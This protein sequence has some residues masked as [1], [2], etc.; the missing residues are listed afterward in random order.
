MHAD[1][2]LAVSF[3]G[4]VINVKVDVGYRVYFPYIV[5]VVYMKTETL[6]VFVI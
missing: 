1:V 2:G 6:C 4:S 5:F 3:N